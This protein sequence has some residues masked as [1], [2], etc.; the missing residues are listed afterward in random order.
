MGEVPTLRK[1]SRVY[2]I[3]YFDEAGEEMFAGE[4]RSVIALEHGVERELQFMDH[5]MQRG[6]HSY[7]VRLKRPAEVRAMVREQKRAE[8]RRFRQ[9]VANETLSVLGLDMESMMPVIINMSRMRQA[10]EL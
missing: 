7:S 2:D 10:G 5:A 9:S 4:P 1:D 6:A 8:A 3:S